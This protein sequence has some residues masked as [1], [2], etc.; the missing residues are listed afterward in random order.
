MTI[1]TYEEFYSD[2]THGIIRSEADA[3]IIGIRGDEE[4]VVV[5]DQKWGEF[6]PSANGFL[7]AVVGNEL[8]PATYD[9]ETESI[10]VDGVESTY[11]EVYNA[12]NGI[13]RSVD[14]S[15]IAGRHNGRD[16]VIV[17]DRKWGEFTPSFVPPTVEQIGDVAGFMYTS[18]SAVSINA[19]TKQRLY[20]N[21]SVSSSMIVYD[22]GKIYGI[23]SWC[24]QGG[25]PS[26][27]GNE[28]SLR[29]TYTYA[30]GG[31]KLA[32]GKETVDGSA[33]IYAII[34]KMCENRAQLTRVYNTEGLRFDA[35]ECEG[36]Y[37][38]LDFIHN[39]WV[40]DLSAIGYTKGTS[41]EVL[42]RFSS[43][44]FVTFNSN[45]YW[46]GLLKSD[47]SEQLALVDSIGFPIVD[48][49]TSGWKNL[50]FSRNFDYDILEIY[51]NAEGTHSAELDMGNFWMG[52]RDNASNQLYIQNLAAVSKQVVSYRLRITK[53]S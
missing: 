28:K 52:N 35:F 33:P 9:D 40:R 39:E 4:F 31:N 25:V 24:T 48:S 5:C 20:T 38:V 50:Q 14:D 27:V 22:S 13:V 30:S 45:D 15:V 42:L 21:A 37:Y 6:T 53:R 43:N 44:A 3:H 51:T 29:I 18:T 23:R 46:F 11:E 32:L 12:G 16:C 19:K 17:A 10:E 1:Y 34:I 41:V 49:S 8:K 2:P 26:T 47:D 7:F 36:Y